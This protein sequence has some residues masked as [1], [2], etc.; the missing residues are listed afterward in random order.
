VVQMLLLETS[1]YLLAAVFLCVELF[2]FGSSFFA[3]EAAP[4]CWAWWQ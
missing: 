1:L 4:T 3:A 2:V